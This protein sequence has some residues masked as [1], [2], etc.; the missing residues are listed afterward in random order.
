MVVGIDFFFFIYMSK[1]SR[2][3]A[4]F[5]SMG[6]RPLKKAAYD[7]PRGQSGIQK[8]SGYT[9]VARTRGV[10]GRGEMKYFDTEHISAAITVV[11]TTWPAG[12]QAPPSNPACLT[13]CVPQV[14]AAINQRIG[15]EIKVYK[16]RIKG[17]FTIPAQSAQ[18]AS[19]NATVIRYLL[20]QDMQT[21]AAAMTSAQL[22][23]DQTNA[24][25]TI[26]TYQ[27]LSNVG[28]FK[29]LK[30]KTIYFS[31][32][33]LAGSPTAGDLVQSGMKIP[34]KCTYNFKR[35]PVSMRF[36]ATN[37]G[38]IADIIDNSFHFLCGTDNIALVP[39]LAYVC[40]VC[41]KE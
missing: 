35:S 21:N 12:T 11:T 7:W 16:I 25:T 28:R 36:N 34:F 19:D 31:N 2:Q 13:L 18:S 37:G 22:L 9:T 4:G 32:A 14:G 5:T 15:R 24:S 23:A 10:Y 30:D 17:H 1:R 26:D 41:Y 39:E 33:N 29:V 8:R 6:N 20:V 3:D 40:R 27:N 38:T